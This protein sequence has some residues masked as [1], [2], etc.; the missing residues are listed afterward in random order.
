MK[1]K[2]RSRA[3]PGNFLEDKRKILCLFEQKF[4]LTKKKND[5]NNNAKWAECVH[6]L[7]FFFL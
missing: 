6:D 4:G 1:K 2:K 3:I 7:N 5:T